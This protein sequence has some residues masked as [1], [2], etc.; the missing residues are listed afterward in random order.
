ME[1]ED[2]RA[3]LENDDGRAEPGDCGRIA[4][5]QPTGPPATAG[6]FI[7]ED[8]DG[9]NS[10]SDLAHRLAQQA[11]AVCRHYLSNGRREGRYWLGGRRSQYARPLDVRA[12]QRSRNPVRAPPGTGPMPPRPSMAIC[13]T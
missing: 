5:E 3:R 10:A 2:G 13:S 11:E 6:L 7:F 4:V 12:A 8:I 1:D 9:R